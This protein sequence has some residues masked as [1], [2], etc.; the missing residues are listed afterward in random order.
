[1][2]R[3][4]WFFAVPLAAIALAIGF[5][6]GAVVPR[7]PSPA[8]SPTVTEQGPKPAMTVEPK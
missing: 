8:P 5:W 3:R 2:W 6:I 4:P 1:M 7:T